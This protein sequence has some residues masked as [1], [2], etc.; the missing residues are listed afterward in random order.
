MQYSLG[1][2]DDLLKIHILRTIPWVYGFA[3]EEAEEE[4][5]RLTKT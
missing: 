1:I 5:R 4:I 3:P 2:R